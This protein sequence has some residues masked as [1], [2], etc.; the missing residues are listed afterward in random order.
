M[1]KYVLTVF[2]SLLSGVM[3]ILPALAQDDLPLK[4]PKP[5][6]YY[7]GEVGHHIVPASVGQAAELDRQADA[8]RRSGDLDAAQKLYREAIVIAPLVDAYMH[9]ADILATK[10]NP[11]K[12]AEIYRYVIHPLPETPEK[13]GTLQSIPLFR[14]ALYLSEAGKTQ[15]SL[16]IYSYA[17]FDSGSCIGV[18]PK[19]EFINKQGFDRVLFRA[20]CHLGIGLELRNGTDPDYASGFPSVDLMAVPSDRKEIVEATVLEP[21]WTK[22]WLALANAMEEE[23]SENYG[24]TPK[25][26][27][28]NILLGREAATHYLELAERPDSGETPLEVQIVESWK[29]RWFNPVWMQ[30]RGS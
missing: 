7:V 4:M 5:T 30:S 10:G 28:G 12:A 29:I 9:Y 3:L 24:S 22:A 18:L 25:Q 27:S 2:M 6:L 17:I 11:A 15:K 8:L 19:L 20:A 13:Q 14:L 1:I 23:V 21:D 26:R 16:Q